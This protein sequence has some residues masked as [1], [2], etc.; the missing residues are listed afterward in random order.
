M[1]VN[2]ILV[3]Y[4]EIHLKGKNRGY[5]EKILKQNINSKIQKFDATIEIVSGRYIVHGFKEDSTHEIIDVLTK[6]PGIHSVSPA[7]EID[8]NLDNI[9]DIAVSL[10]K[11]KFGT[12]RVSAT[13]ADKSFPVN[14]MDLAKALGG[15][16]LKSNKE[17]SVDLHNPD[18]NIQVDIRQNGKTYLFFEII[19]GVSGMP[20]STSGNGLLLLSGGI[21]SPVAG[22]MMIKRGLKLSAIHFESFPYTSPQAKQKA[23]DL[24]RVLAKYNG[25]SKLY[26]ANISK[27]QEAIHNNCHPDYMITLI[28][29]FMLRIAEKL[30]NDKHLQCLVSGESLAQV[31]SQTIESMTTIGSVLTSN[32]PFFKP[33]IGFDKLETIAISEKIGTYEISIKPYDDCCTVFLPDS[34][35]IKPKLDKVLKQEERIDVE[36]LIEDCYKNIE[37]IEIDIK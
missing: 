31:A 28:R 2:A 32:R 4:A 26:I 17:L 34:P 30:A 16:I 33:L 10:M 27:I 5:F 15:E 6:T 9:K 22:Y 23:I 35:V 24:M 18:Y 25:P 29:R 8:T 7:F 19:N 11:D 20:V 21:D 37:I 1:S 14:S 13:R 3:R 12:F 36:G